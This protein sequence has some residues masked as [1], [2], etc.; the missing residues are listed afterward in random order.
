[1]SEN[2][3]LNEL[4]VALQNNNVIYNRDYHKE[5]M[6]AIQGLLD[7]Y[8]KEKEKNKEIKERIEYYYNNGGSTAIVVND[9]R[10]LLEE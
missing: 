10:E 3:I 2:E 4:E 8:N 6:T 7:L 1:M 5:I 9:I